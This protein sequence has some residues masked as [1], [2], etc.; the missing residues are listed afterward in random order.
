[1]NNCCSSGYGSSSRVVVIWLHIRCSFYV[2]KIAA[3]TEDVNIIFTKGHCEKKIDNIFC[4]PSE[5][6]YGVTNIRFYI[7][8]N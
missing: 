8:K 2:A 7:E 5:N 3:W 6:K 4:K 1:M